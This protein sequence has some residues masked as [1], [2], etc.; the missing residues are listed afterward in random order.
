MRAL[1]EVRPTIHPMRCPNCGGARIALAAA[2]GEAPGGT[3]VCLACAFLWDDP[4]RQHL[5]V[6]G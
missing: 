2:P 5:R 3:C 6:D 1:S 4:D